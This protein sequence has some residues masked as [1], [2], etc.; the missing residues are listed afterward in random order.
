MSWINSI[1]GKAAWIVSWIDSKHLS[2]ELIRIKWNWVVP[3]SGAHVY[4]RY[5]RVDVGMAVARAS[6]YDCSYSGFRISAKFQHVTLQESRVWMVGRRSSPT[7]N[8]DA[9]DWLDNIADNSIHQLY[10]I[11]LHQHTGSSGWDHRTPRWTRPHI[12]GHRRSFETICGSYHYVPMHRRL[13]AGCGTSPASG[14]TK[15]RTDWK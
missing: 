12:A 3:K 11:I 9:E 10:F 4:G 14:W 7:V 8:Q 5:G 15:S 13:R 2:G 1:H 6:K